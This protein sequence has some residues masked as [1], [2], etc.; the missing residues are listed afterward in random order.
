MVGV[1]LDLV[2]KD[3]IKALELYEKIFDIEVVEVS[4]F[5]RG[6]NEAV[7]TFIRRSLSSFR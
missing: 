5:P 3:S 6:E 1:E 7:F 2:V 4:N